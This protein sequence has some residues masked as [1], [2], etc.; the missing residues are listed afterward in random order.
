MIQKQSELE[1]IRSNCK[2]MEINAKGGYEKLEQLQYERKQLEREV[3]NYKDQELRSES[4]IHLQPTDTFNNEFF[5]LNTFSGANRGRTEHRSHRRRH[6]F[7]ENISNN[8][9]LSPQ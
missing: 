2:L 3:R 9:T 7:S 1:E 4:T 8:F 6:S 5:D